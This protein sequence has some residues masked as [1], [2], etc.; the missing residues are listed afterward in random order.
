MARKSDRTSREN[1]RLRLIS[2]S[3]PFGVTE[4]YK[5]L[6]ANLQFVCPHEGC[7]I[8]CMTSPYSHEG[9]SSSAL[10]TSFTIAESAQR[11]LFLDAD[12]RASHVARNL[13]LKKGPGLADLLSREV[14]ETAVDAVIQKIEG[15][16]NLSVIVS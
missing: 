10:N 8:I 12:M 13:G 1:E 11:V 2:S 6:R 5:T 16:D 15:K 14:D 3:T 7:K 9:K 4:A